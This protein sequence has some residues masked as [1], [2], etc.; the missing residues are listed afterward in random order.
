MNSNSRT[1][2]GLVLVALGVLFLV[3]QVG[4]VDAGEAIGRLWP[5]LIIAFG[6]AQALDERR[7]SVGPLIIIGIGVLLLLSRLEIVPWDAWRL[8]WPLFIIGLGLLLIFRRLG[9]APE[10]RDDEVV[11]ASTLFSG[12]TLVSSSRNFK[13]GQLNAT[14]GGIELDL[15]QAQLAAEGAVLSIFAAFGGV[16]VLV[17]RGWRVQT[18]GVPIFG[19]LENKTTAAA[20]PSGPLLRVDATVVFGGAEVKHEK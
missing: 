5:L 10:G 17:P 8:F 9:A 18:S 11:N 14:F 3:D 20:D 16:E 13:G 19:G 12:N 2:F 1:V 7:L 15:R 4:G 6:V